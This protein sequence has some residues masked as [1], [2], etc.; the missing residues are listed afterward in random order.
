MHF[1]IC[2]YTDIGPL[3]LTTSAPQT[4]TPPSV[5]FKLIQHNARNRSDAV[6]R[7]PI[8][9]DQ[10]RENVNAIASS[11]QARPQNNDSPTNENRTK[12]AN[13]LFVPGVL[14]ISFSLSQ[15]LYPKYVTDRS[16]LTAL[17]PR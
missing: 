15:K 11:S 5:S 16:P 6:V 3:P 9:I 17:N 7:T 14:W 12:V 1:L 10:M 13:F 4:A 2:F 8:L